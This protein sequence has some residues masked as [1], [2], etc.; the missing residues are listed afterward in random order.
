MKVFDG[1]RAAQEYMSSHTLAFS[2]P[3]LTLTRFAFWLGEMVPDPAD[4]EKTVPRLYTFVEEKDFE[5]VQV[6]DDE[7]YV[8][9][10]AVRATAMYG[11]PAGI[12][13]SKFCAE[14]GAGM[15]H[16][17]KFCPQCGESWNTS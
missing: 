16:G 13:S 12:G 3:E 7:K 17:A 5:P 6:I 9:T 15:S 11:T 2:T 8:P 10:G 1:R 14:C 4:G